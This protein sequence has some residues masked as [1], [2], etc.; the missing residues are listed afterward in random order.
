MLIFC[1]LGSRATCPEGFEIHG[2]RCYK[3]LDVLSSWAEAKVYCS[4]I[5]GDLA[6]IDDTHEYAIIT[7]IIQRLHGS[8]DIRH[9]IDGSDMLAENEWRWMGQHGESKPMTYTKWYPGQPDNAGGAE[10][11]LELVNNWQGTYNDA[12]GLSATCPEGFENHGNRCYKVLD[13]LSSW[14]EAKVYCSVIGGDLA[15]VDDANEHALI[16]GMIQRL[17]GSNDVHHWIDGSDILA[18]NEWRWMGK[19]GGSK[20]MT[21]T[22]WYPGEPDNAYAIE[23]FLELINIWHGAFNDAPGDAKRG[24]VC[25]ASRLDTYG[26][27]QLRTLDNLE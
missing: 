3:V 22:K 7:G 27:D 24:F 5:G 1:T 12:L 25:E 21:Y 23:H 9:W 6:A 11:F 4:V 17:H 16:T 13:V 15:I 26:R 19:H 2:S 8:A 14:A 20:P 10:H 18:E